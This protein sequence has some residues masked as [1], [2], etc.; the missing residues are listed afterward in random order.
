MTLV[1]EVFL[2][3]L[4]DLREGTGKPVECYL[5]RVPATARR[6]L[7]DL[8]AS[9]FAS[10]TQPVDP[11]TNAELFE[12]TLETVDRV[13]AE[14]S[15][16][17]GVLPSTLQELSRTRGLRRREL[18]SQLRET[19]GLPQQSEPALAECYH[20]LESGQVPGPSISKRLLAGLAA[21]IRIP[22]DELEAAS[23]PLG[24]PRR[25]DTVAGFARGGRPGADVNGEAPA[26]EPT[27]PD[28]SCA[29]EVH[30]LF[31]GG[32]DA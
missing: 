7:A 5:E 13:I 15:G 27:P 16:V 30:A 31:Y 24:P 14:H 29:R 26:D 4:E 20:R 10:R 19:L 23:R 18:V 1:D 2:E 6:Q 3:A 21:V 11:H 25:P 8:L 9:F 28:D 32:R 17:A 12:R 22:V